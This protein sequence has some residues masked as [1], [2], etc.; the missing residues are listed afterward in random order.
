MT[1]KW[2]SIQDVADELGINKMTVYRLVHGGEIPGYR[3]KRLFR[4][5]QEDLD[6]YIRESQVVP[7]QAADRT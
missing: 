4:V 3:F 6:A 5:K 7:E 1:V 2:L